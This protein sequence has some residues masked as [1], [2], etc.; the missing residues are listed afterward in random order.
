MLTNSATRTL[1]SLSLSLWER[2]MYTLR[3]VSKQIIHVSLRQ[4]AHVKIY[5]KD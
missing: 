3:V 2:F 1:Y 5:F 4:L